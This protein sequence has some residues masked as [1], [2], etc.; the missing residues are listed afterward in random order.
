MQGSTRLCRLMEEKDRA[1]L[2]F[3]GLDIAQWLLLASAVVVKEVSGRLH[4]LYSSVL[5]RMLAF[6][7]EPDKGLESM[8]RLQNLLRSIPN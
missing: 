8:H 3:V 2:E 7:P 6:M 5:E 4:E 1:R